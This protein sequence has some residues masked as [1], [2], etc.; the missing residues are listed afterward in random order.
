MKYRYRPAVI[1]AVTAALIS[2]S[3]CKEADYNSEKWIRDQAVKTA[4]KYARS[5]FRDP[6]M[7]VAT[8]GS[9]FYSQ[10]NTRCMIDPKYIVTGRIDS[11]TIKDAMV[12]LFT[13]TGESLPVKDHLVLLNTTKDMQLVKEYTGEMRI[14]AI[15]N[16]EILIE[17]SHMA[18]DSP[19]GNCE[20]C[21]V[22]R[23]YRFE[24]GDTV[25]IK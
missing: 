21:K 6:K 18:Y 15:N 19:N 24:S 12:T 13:F 1:I 23:K 2:G 17:T 22:V 20:L 14:I 25:E 11:D 4:E 7:D 8:N 5:K 9:I 3:G 10:D 16:G